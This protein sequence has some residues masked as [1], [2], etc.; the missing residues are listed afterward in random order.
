M[1]DVRINLNKGDKK[2]VEGGFELRRLFL[3]HVKGKVTDE[4]F[5][6][7]KKKYSKNAQM[8]VQK[9][10]SECSKDKNLLDLVKSMNK[11]TKFYTDS[12][13]EILRQQDPATLNNYVLSLRND[14]K[15]FMSLERR[16][17]SVALQNLPH[18]INGVPIFLEDALRYIELKSRTKG[19]Y[20]Q[21][22]S[23]KET[24]K[25]FKIYSKS[26]EKLTTLPVHLVCS[27]V[28]TFFD[29]LPRPVLPS[30]IKWANIGMITPVAVL[31][32]KLFVEIRRLNYVYRTVLERFI[33]HMRV[34]ATQQDDSENT[35]ERLVENTHPSLFGRYGK[36]KCEA[37]INIIVS[38][39]ENTF[40]FFGPETV[41]AKGFIK[42]P[43]QVNKEGTRM[44]KKACPR[45]YTI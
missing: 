21:I 37:E 22:H 39:I 29:E 13:V 40:E 18:Y 30:E 3:N 33:W 41:I 19:L 17:L 15:N 10:I 16:F 23:Y 45:R 27:A 24:K 14:L 26:P 38:M 43:P 44:P 12:S 42:S 36:E 6:L 31:E 11:K 4:Y 35:L 7:F 32:P 34:L 28:L 5:D 25:V 2:Y 9:C 20:K 8:F 1:Q